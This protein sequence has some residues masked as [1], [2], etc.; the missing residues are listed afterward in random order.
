MIDWVTWF[1][2]HRSDDITVGITKIRQ[3]TFQKRAGGGVEP[4]GAAAA[5]GG[6]Q[7]AAAAGGDD[8]ASNAAD[9]GAPD[10]DGHG[11]DCLGCSFLHSLS[12]VPSQDRAKLQKILEPHGISLPPIGKSKFTS[13]MGGKQK[14]RGL[15]ENL[16]PDAQY[17]MTYKTSM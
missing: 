15:D 13:S 12:F 6:G 5:A 3:I 17:I 4:E 10:H 7:Q 1:K 8:A 9:A 14:K 11:N 16:G 2:T